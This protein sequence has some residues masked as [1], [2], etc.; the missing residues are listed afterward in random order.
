MKKKSKNH[1]SDQTYKRKET[2]DT[3][4][5]LGDFINQ[6]MLSKLKE[7]QNELTQKELLAKEQEEL[8]KKE[9][10]KQREKNKSF[11]DLLNESTTDWR[12]FK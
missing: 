3:K 1:K 10:R 6:D 8:R 4:M 7:A 9:E 11:E 2:D 12:K 5:T